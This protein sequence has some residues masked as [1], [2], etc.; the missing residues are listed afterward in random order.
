MGAEVEEFPDGMNIAGGQP[1]HGVA[2]ES[3]GDHRIAMSF[4][5]AALAASGETRIHHAECA[6]V[7][8]PG[9]FDALARLRSNLGPQALSIEAA[10]SN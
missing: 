8:F 3:H 2:I 9:F 7:S 4:A 10:K 5:V 6:D 1:L